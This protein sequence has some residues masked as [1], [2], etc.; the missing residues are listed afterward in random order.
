MQKQNSTA[1]EKTQ[2][3]IIGKV[4]KLLSLADKA[5][6]TSEA[7]AEMAMLKAQELMAKYGVSVDSSMPEAIEHINVSCEHPWNMGYRKPLASV[8]AKNFRCRCWCSGNTVMFLGRVI[9]ALIAKE[10]FEYA[11]KFI[12]EGSGKAY[13]KAYQ[14]GI[15]TKGVYNSYAL[16]FING[17]E[18]KFEEQCV[19]LM[20]V[21]PQ[22]VVDEYNK[23]T[24]DWKPAKGGMRM[25]KLNL[26]VYNEGFHD[27]KTAMNGRRIED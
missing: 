17:L 11:Y 21:T 23:M 18:S 22:D 10:T 7:E 2:E 6:N 19:A 20:I 16:G 3:A 8:I 13:N 25:N 24:A 27:G 5:K 14:M 9:D 15:Q 1:D 4:R 12:L 26:E